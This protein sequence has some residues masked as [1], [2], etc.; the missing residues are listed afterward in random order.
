MGPLADM[1]LLVNDP[2]DVVKMVEKLEG[3][4]GS[5]RH[6]VVS[7]GTFKTLERMYVPEDYEELLVTFDKDSTPAT[8]A[9]FVQL[10]NRIVRHRN[11]T[12]LL[13]HPQ[14]EDK[15]VHPSRR[16]LPAP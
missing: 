4:M 15:D 8:S 5:G 9:A 1:L 11:W 2:L 13:T 10:V 6:V 3:R 7:P 16:V 12:W 14:L